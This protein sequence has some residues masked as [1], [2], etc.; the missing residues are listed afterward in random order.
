MNLINKF[1][2]ESK[3]DKLDSD[4]T[5]AIDLDGVIHS[6]D[7]GWQDGSIY[8]I[9]ISGTEEA[10]K[11]L[12]SRFKRIII[13]TCRTRKDQPLIHGKSQ[14]DLIWE[15]LKKYELDK[16]ISQITSEKPMA[17]F[18]IDDHGIKFNSWQQ[19]LRDIK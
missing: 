1:L 11:R 7:K 19:T 13:F 10:L 6:Y 16:Y 5:I 15:W 12:K 17:S 4:K 8:G 3:K 18:Y 14:I 9:P 2:E